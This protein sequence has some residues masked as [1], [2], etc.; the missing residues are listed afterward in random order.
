MFYTYLL[1]SKN[2]NTLYISSTIDLRKRINLHNSG[3]VTSTR[4]RG[5]L[6]LIYY[7]AYKKERD[8]KVREHNL[9]LKAN[10]LSQLKR[11]LRESLKA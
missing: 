6:E 4:N 8:A 2:G 1:K 7:E 5:P 3:Q 9:K 11:R 10:A